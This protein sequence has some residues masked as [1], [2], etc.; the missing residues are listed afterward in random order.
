MYFS[1]GD[2]SEVTLPSHGWSWDC[3]WPWLLGSDPSSFQSTSGRGETHATVQRQQDVPAQC[4]LTLLHSQAGAQ[5]LP[6]HALPFPC[7]STF[8]FTPCPAPALLAG[9]TRL[10][11]PDSSAGHGAD[12][13]L[14]VPQCSSTPPWQSPEEELLDSDT[15]THMGSSATAAWGAPDREWKDGIIFAGA[16]CSPQPGGSATASSVQMSVHRACLPSCLGS[17]EEKKRIAL[18]SAARSSPRRP[19]SRSASCSSTGRSSRA[20]SRSSHRRASP[21]SSRSRSCSSGRR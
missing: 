16:C 13:L 12:E 3:N 6:C 4:P 15:H 21:S 2:S 9:P 14:L 20:S 1:H 5:P 19:G 18:P 17:S 10:C 11:Q 7:S 8:D